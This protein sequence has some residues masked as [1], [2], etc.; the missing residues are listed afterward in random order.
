MTRDKKPY[1][2]LIIED[3]PGD[4]IIVDDLLR[5]QIFNPFIRH[6]VDYKQA[7]AILAEPDIVFDIILLDLS[8]PDKSGQ[9]LINEMLFIAPSYP[10]IILT[11]Y[12]D[13]EFSI[14]SISQGIYDYL[15][16]DDLN[17]ISLYK[18]IVYSIERKKTISELISSE[19]RASD[20]FNLSPQPMW[21][22]DE[23]SFQF[24]EVNDAAVRHYGFTKEEFLNMTIM[25]IRQVVGLL[26]TNDKIESQKETDAEI[27][28]GKFTHRKKSGEL[29]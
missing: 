1:R 27:F 26:K 12:T 22:F 13:I 21:I 29:I 19:K 16:K 28:K 6:A 23:G 18:S 20:L 5:D 14:K 11:G 25:D 2:I 8:L 24:A 17:S 15:L 4:F 10:I 9:S 7:V 3:N